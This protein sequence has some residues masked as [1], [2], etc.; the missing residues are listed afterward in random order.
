MRFNNEI[1]TYN[2]IKN[3]VEHYVYKMTSGSTTFVLLYVDNIILI[4]NAIGMLSLVKA[5]YK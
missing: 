2:F 1:M 3:E 5:C 4:M